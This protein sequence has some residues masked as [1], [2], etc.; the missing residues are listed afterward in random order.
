MV[1]STRSAARKLPPTSASKSKNASK[2]ASKRGNPSSAKSKSAASKAAAKTKSLFHYFSPSPSKK[3]KAAANTKP[4]FHYF[5]PSPSKKL[6]N[7]EGSPTKGGNRVDDRE[8]ATKTNEDDEIEIVKVI[9][10][11]TATIPPK[12]AVDG[13]HSPPVNTTQ[14]KRKSPSPLCHLNPNLIKGQKDTCAEDSSVKKSKS[15]TGECLFGVREKKG[16][17]VSGPSKLSATVTSNRSSRDASKLDSGEQMEM[18]KRNTSTKQN[19]AILDVQPTQSGAMAL[20]P[21]RNATTNLEELCHTLQIDPTKRNV[22]NLS[23]KSILG[24]DEPKVKK[25]KISIDISTLESGI[26]RKQILVKSINQKQTTDSAQ[27]NIQCDKDSSESHLCNY[28]KDMQ[29]RSST[30]TVCNKGKN[31]VLVCKAR[32]GKDVMG[33]DCLKGYISRLDEGCSILLKGKI[34]SNL[35]HSLLYDSCCPNRLFNFVTFNKK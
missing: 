35:N 4:L 19:K 27:V 23:E 21:I 18:G 33:R 11:P 10:S 30:V 34:I 22:Y 26:S 17:Q 29:D 2:N 5:S 6:K 13:S 12:S 16:S 25:N 32:V 31:A 14:L 28:L 20:I 1:R 3:S 15:G 9:R 7:T 8:R 24:R